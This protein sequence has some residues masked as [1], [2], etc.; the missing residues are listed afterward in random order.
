MKR[1]I[2]VLISVLLIG[3][4]ISYSYYNLTIAQA[5]T[6][7]WFWSL[8]PTTRLMIRTVHAE[9]KG[10]PYLAKVAVAAVMMN[11]VRDKRFPNTIAGVIYQPWAFTPV[12]H[13]LIWHQR[14]SED[15][16]KAT[17]AAMRGWDP[18]YGCVY[19]YNPATSTSRWI[20]SRRTVRKIGKHIFAK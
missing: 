17:L 15:S 18:T 11:R 4:F 12:A 1:K 20:Y 9:S 14:P 8:S 2:L 10:E 19:F 16:I 6:P 13:G 3:M 7:S 5:Q